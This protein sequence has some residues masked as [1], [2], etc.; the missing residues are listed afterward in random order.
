M[1][2]VIRVLVFIIF[3]LH[4]SRLDLS[5]FFVA[6]LILLLLALICQGLN[7]PIAWS[8]L[9]RLRWLFLSILILYAWFTPG[10]A[11]FDLPQTGFMPTYEG[12][13]AGALQ[14][15]SLILIVTAL[16][17]LVSG[18]SRDRLLAAIYW[19]SR[20]VSLLGIPRERL[21]V[22]LVLA[23]SYVPRLQGHLS[24]VMAH[25]AQTELKGLRRI[26]AVAGSLFIEVQQRAERAETESVAIATLPAPPPL[27]WFYPVLVASLFILLH[28]VATALLGTA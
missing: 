3:S 11:L 24:E 20:P 17:I 22:R 12:L 5:E 26:A 15:S 9:K 10:Q 1:H 7:G 4:A 14:V 2:P 13:Q 27:Q 16:V 18:L 6:V 23:M 21:V 28:R 8:F 25:S 19:L